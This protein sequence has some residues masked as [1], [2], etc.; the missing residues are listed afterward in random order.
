MKRKC[1]KQ[2]V[3]CHETQKGITLISLVI[4]IILL[5]IL[6]G[7]AINFAIGENGIFKLAKDATEKY[8]NSAEKEEAEIAKANEYIANGRETVVI[9][10]EEY[11]SLIPSPI[12]EDSLLMSSNNRSLACQ[13]INLTSFTNDFSDSFENYFS[14]DS[15]TGELTCKKAGWYMVKLEMYIDNANGSLTSS[16]VSLFINNINIGNAKAIG[17]ADSVLQYDCNT[18]TF[19]VK[20]EEKLKFSKDTIGVGARLSEWRYYIIV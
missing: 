4:T 6:A 18:I 5:L 16:A 3:T 20:P 8:K 13:N 11:E 1:I 12:G 14:Y 7:V 9:S 15:T 17:R 10:K 2:M 19:Y